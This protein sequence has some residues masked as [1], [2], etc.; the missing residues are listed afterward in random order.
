MRSLFSGFWSQC[1]RGVF[2]CRWAEGSPMAGPRNGHLQQNT[3][4]VGTSISGRDQNLYLQNV[5]L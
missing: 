2:G 1:N 5:T 4:I 3:K